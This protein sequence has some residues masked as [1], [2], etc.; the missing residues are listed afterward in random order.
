MSQHIRIKFTTD[1]NTASEIELDIRKEKLIIE[2]DFFK[3]LYS[4]T[5][6]ESESKEIL[7]E[8]TTSYHNSSALKRFFGFI[9]NFPQLSG[10]SQSI[11][12]E[13]TYESTSKLGLHHVKIDFGLGFDTDI[14]EINELLHLCNY[15]YFNKLRTYLLVRM[16]SYPS[17][18]KNADNCAFDESYVIHTELNIKIKQELLAKDINDYRK[19]IIIEQFIKN[20]YA[21]FMFYK[22]TDC[23]DDFEECINIVNANI[24]T[25][26]SESGFNY[27][28]NVNQVIELITIGNDEVMSIP[29]NELF[30][31]VKLASKIIVVKPLFKLYNFYDILDYEVPN[32]KTFDFNCDNNCIN[33]TCKKHRISIIESKNV[34]ANESDN[35]EDEFDSSS[36]SEEE[37]PPKA[38]KRRKPCAGRSGCNTCKDQGIVKYYSTEEDS[39]SDSEYHRN[40]DSGSDDEVPFHNAIVPAKFAS[41]DEEDEEE[42]VA[43]PRKVI[44]KKSCKSNK[45]NLVENKNIF[46]NNSH[47][48][49][50]GKK[51]VIPIETFQITINKIFPDFDW[52]NVI[53]AGGYLYG[54]IDNIH[55]S[56]L[57]GS[58]IDLFVYGADPEIIKGKTEYILSYFSKHNSYY[59]VNG[60]VITLIIPDLPYDIQ[61]VSYNC[62][63][64]LSV[65]KKIDYN[66]VKMFFDGVNIFCTFNCLMAIKYKIAI[67]E[68]ISNA[69]LDD[70][71]LYKTI[72]KGLRLMYDSDVQSESHIDLCKL[73]NN[74]EIEFALNKSICIRKLL[75]VVNRYEITHLI[76]AYYKGHIVTENIT[77][78]NIIIG[79]DSGEYKFLKPNINFNEIVNIKQSTTS[80]KCQVKYYCFE[81][82]NGKI[83]N[84]ISLEIDFCRWRRGCGHFVLI[85]EDKDMQRK[86]INLYN[87]MFDIVT[88]KIRQIQSMYI[89]NNY[90]GDDMP[91]FA[92][93]NI[94]DKVNLS[95][96]VSPGKDLV[97]IIKNAN[98]MH[99]LKVTCHGG[100]WATRST[101]GI[102]F[103][104]DSIVVETSA[105][106]SKGK[107]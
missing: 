64:P 22:E 101:C 27:F 85:I 57:P 46:N 32:I 83:L 50:I 23:L 40:E 65:M 105:N 68:N 87:T 34:I 53:L 20:I 73:H 104:A 28:K 102:K 86:I 42:E 75:P 81:L 77:E 30:E 99:R 10:S 7:I 39:S 55:E 97:D 44:S 4:N 14:S 6:K 24:N 37:L 103:F 92:K 90:G 67:Y 52:H 96:H 58:D 18:L 54:M 43:I 62:P 11:R 9:D 63:D 51:T 107:K 21:I 93:R 61:I 94:K 78:V 36:S 17:V 19:K 106:K 1:S 71:R 56:I 79:D 16:K 76:K 38:C 35:E 66:Y 82:Q 91:E 70:T 95:V 60:S 89:G 13:P 100:F 74:T 33:D 5:Y 59:V 80:T 88:K 15:F 29:L 26:R 8:L 48:E 47:A 45:I 3:S 98:E 41:S 72:I 49:Y 31:L 25:K 12:T 84:H 69:K 2:C